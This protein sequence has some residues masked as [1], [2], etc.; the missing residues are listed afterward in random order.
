[1]YVPRGIGV[2]G[3]QGTQGTCERAFHQVAQRHVCKHVA[4]QREQLVSLRARPAE[5][6]AR[7][8][9]AAS[10]V[11]GS[12]QRDGVRTVPGVLIMAITPHTYVPHPS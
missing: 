10:A 2:W 8:V 9:L 6:P 3:M 7:Y 11:H 4:Q 5:T 12:C 1:M